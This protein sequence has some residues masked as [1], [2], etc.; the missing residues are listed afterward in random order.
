MGGSTGRLV[1]CGYSSGA[2]CASLYAM[3]EK[4]SEFESV[5]L[6]SGIYDIH[7]DAWTG[8]M[9]YLAPVINV[10]LKDIVGAVT[11]ELREK[12]SP[13]KMVERRLDGMDWHVLNAESELLGIQPFQDLLFSSDALCE[14]LTSKGANVH[15]ATCGHN[16][17]LLIFSFDAYVRKFA[18][19]RA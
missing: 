5:L 7:T 9:S 19:C 4:A 2:H 11:P 1:L 17:W 16:H 10:L 15:R 14:Q 6:I 8:W 12:L 13:V 3:S 18:Y